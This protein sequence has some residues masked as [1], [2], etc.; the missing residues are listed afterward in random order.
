MI[1]VPRVPRRIAGWPGRWWS[2]ARQALGKGL[3]ALI[4]QRLEVEDSDPGTSGLQ[5]VDID[6]V[7]PNRSQ[8]RRHFDE[9]KL[10]ELGESIKA[11]GMLQPLVVR[12]VDGGFEI[13]AGERRWRAARMVGLEKVPVI[14]GD[15]TDKEVMEVALIENLQREDLNPIEEAEAFRRLIEEFS[16]TQEEV[17]RAV[18]KGRATIANSLRLLSLVPD[19]RQLVAD[20]KLSAGHAKVLASLSDTGQREYAMRVLAEGLSVRQLEELVSGET[21]KSRRNRTRSV[22]SSPPPELRAV[23]ERLQEALGTKV[24]IKAKD[25]K[26]SQGKIEVEFYSVEDL[27]RILDLLG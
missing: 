11:R 14:V 21:K 25:E 27:D 4:P 16:L 12:E 5:E 2:V 10:Q 15:Y 6:L 20:G 17:A 13:V 23:A 8:P 7:V 18:G 26:Y 1:P 3:E 9:E 22:A 19:V 24:T